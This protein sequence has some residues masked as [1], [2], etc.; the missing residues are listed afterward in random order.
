MG[1]LLARQWNDAEICLT[2]VGLDSEL[3]TDQGIVLWSGLDIDVNVR[4]GLRCW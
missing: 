3:I 4:F 2:D 1:R